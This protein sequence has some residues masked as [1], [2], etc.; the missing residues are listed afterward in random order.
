MLNGFSCAYQLFVFFG[1]MSVPILC[2]FF[3][4]LFELKLERMSGSVVWGPDFRGVL[5]G[6]QAHG[7]GG[8][9]GA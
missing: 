2:P 4:G 1:E 7:G 5:E 3:S 8:W 9:E 6:V